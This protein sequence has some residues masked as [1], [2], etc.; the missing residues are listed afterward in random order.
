M[1]PQNGNAWESNPPRLYRPDTDFEDQ[2]AHRD[3]TIPGNRI[4][5]TS[6]SCQPGEVLHG[7]IFLV[8][9]MEI[10]PAI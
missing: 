8:F 2:E 7:S 5:H 1:Y 9:S 10:F 4:I 6:L 3:L